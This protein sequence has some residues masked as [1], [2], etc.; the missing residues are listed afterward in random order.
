MIQCSLNK[1]GR[2][3]CHVFCGKF[4]H[5]SQKN[6]HFLNLIAPILCLIISCSKLNMKGKIVMIKPESPKLRLEALQLISILLLIARTLYFQINLI[7]N[8]QRM[9]CLTPLNTCMTTEYL[10][11]RKLLSTTQ[12]LKQWNWPEKHLIWIQW[13]QQIFTASSKIT[14]TFCVLKHCMIISWSCSKT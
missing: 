3:F 13:R 14:Y 6:W 5:R 2:Q 12:L 4:I 1:T 9:L 7:Q 8:S 11:L 10:V